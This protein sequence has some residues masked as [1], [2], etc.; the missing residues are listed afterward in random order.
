VGREQAQRA[1]V[2]FGEAA[3]R[4]LAGGEDEADDADAVPDRDAEHVGELGMRIGPAPEPRIGPDVVEAQWLALAQHH[5]KHA[6]L[7]RQRADLCLLTGGNAVDHELGERPAIVGHA[8]RR[9]PGAD[10]RSGRANDHLQHVPDRHLAGDGQD[11][12]A[13]PLEDLVAAGIA[14]ADV[15]G[16]IGQG[17]GLL[18]LGGGLLW[19]SGTHGLGR[20]RRSLLAHTPTVPAAGSW[21]LG[22][23]S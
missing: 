17:G 10:Q 5:P 19:L 2:P 3:G 6:V 21:R 20:P 18:W 22:R 15:L 12:L 16:P 9:I 14:L 23:G 7:A 13:D 1:L 11:Y 8:E 4:A